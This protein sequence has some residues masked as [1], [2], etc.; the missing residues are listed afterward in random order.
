M[1]NTRS[2]LYT[3]FT[4]YAKLLTTKI[5]AMWTWTETFNDNVYYCDDLG[6]DHTPV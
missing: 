1:L 2:K 6:H 5:I 4:M 3:F